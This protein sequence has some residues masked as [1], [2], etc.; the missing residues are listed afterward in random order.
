MATDSSIPAWRIPRT[1]E[2]A[3]KKLALSLFFFTTSG[4]IPGGPVVKI[5]KFHCKGHGFLS[6]SEK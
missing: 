6:W 2:P 1:E 4:K 5:P 3:T